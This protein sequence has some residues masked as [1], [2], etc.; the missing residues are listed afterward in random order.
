[1]ISVLY[2]DDEPALL[3][4]GALYL[5]RLGDYSVTTTPGAAEAIDLLQQQNFD[6]IVSDFQMPLMDGISFLKYLKS[7]GNSTPFILF[8]GRGREEVVIEALNNGA[9][10]Y[11]QKGGDPKSQFF[12]LSNAICVAVSRR[13][14]LEGLQRK[15][16]EL[17]AA[18]EEISAAEE[19]LRSNLEIL[20]KQDKDLQDSKNFLD[21][22]ID[23]SPNP[24]WISDINGTLI[25]LNNA[26]C[27]MLQITPEEVVGK[28]NILHDSIVEEQGK[29]PLI[30]SV[31]EK[32]DH[33]SFEITYNTMELQSLPL[34]NAALVYLQVSMFPIRDSMGKITN[35][36]IE[37]INITERKII[38][39]SYR[40]S[41]EVFSKFMHHSP[42]YTYILEVTP[43]ESRI[44][45]AS[46]NFEKMIGI[47]LS[48]MMGKTMYEI[49]PEEFAAK[50]TKD[51]WEV[52]SKGKVLVLMEDYNDCQYSTYKFP[53]VLG[54]KTLVA[55]YTLDISEQKRYEYA[56]RES[57]EMFRMMIET[58][59]VAIYLLSGE[60]QICEY[61]NPTFI[62]TFG[63]TLTDLPKISHWWSLAYPDEQYRR[64]VTVEWNRR[65]QQANITNS[66]IEPIESDVI[67]KDGSKKRVLWGIFSLGEKSYG[68]GLEL[69]VMSNF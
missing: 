5:E 46:D 34:K 53:I 57:E 62:R 38:E 31:F 14:A 52:V 23:Q 63:Y 2:V 21:S 51:N 26:C 19:E 25:K 3:N 40:E 61:L 54:K 17:Q 65:I 7:E 6:V 69:P 39:E 37:H 29:L 41:I 1:M 48:E 32:G 50:M 55:G 60:E 47:P 35:T 27:E 43:D 24:I 64:K 8:T 16:E 33:I 59:P 67:C 58:V 42:I 36:V 11:L 30:R 28:Y 68:Y 12:E 18:Y 4:I 49:F 22:I 10:F 15:N 20:T 56:L 66:P 13:K 44:I 9:D 45:Q